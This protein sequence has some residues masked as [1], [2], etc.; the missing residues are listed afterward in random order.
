M[1][2]VEDVTPDN[3]LVGVYEIAIMAGVKQHT[4]HIW[5]I[6]HKSFPQPAYRLKIGPV[7]RWGDARV[8]LARSGRAITERT[9]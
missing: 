3:E 7:W 1:R 6:R 2:L 5:R 4:I 9:G 8:W